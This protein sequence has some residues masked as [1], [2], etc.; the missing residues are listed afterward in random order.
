MIDPDSRVFADALLQRHAQEC[1]VVWVPSRLRFDLSKSD[2]RVFEALAKDSNRFR[3]IFAS[4]QSQIPLESTSRPH[5]GRHFY[6]LPNH[7]R[8]CCYSLS[9]TESIFDAPTFVFKGTEPLLQDYA[10]LLDW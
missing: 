2:V 3:S 9:E 8:S 10:L 4:F 7:Y 6:R 5:T 1:D